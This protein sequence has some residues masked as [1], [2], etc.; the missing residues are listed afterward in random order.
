MMSLHDYRDIHTHRAT[1]P[2]SILSVPAGEVD[3]LTARNRSLPEPLRQPYSL[4]LHPWHLTGDDDILQFTAAARRL[5]A[6]PCLVAIGE[7]GLDSA[8]ATPPDLQR[9][10]FRS[11]L[12]A[13]RELR[14]PVIVHCVRL[15]AEMLHDVHQCFPDLLPR[16]DGQSPWPQPIIVHGYR[17]GPEL[18]RQLLD[19]GL[20]LSLGA[21]HHPAIPSLVPPERLYFETDEEPAP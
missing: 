1:G 17:K 20:S 16:R 8:C 5:A 14:R 18:A 6:D 15:W 7:C 19:A 3:A 21:H 13:A 2:G 11:A 10:A 12:T 9:R 4:Q